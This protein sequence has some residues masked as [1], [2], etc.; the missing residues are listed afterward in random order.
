MAR[1]LVSRNAG[2]HPIAAR[3]DEPA[4]P[5]EPAPPSAR[6]HP[7]RLWGGGAL[8]VAYGVA[9]SWL[10][11]FV[12]TA[13]FLGAFPWVGGLRRPAL[14]AA[15]SV[16]GSFVLFVVFMRVAYISL[17]L[18]EGPFRTLSI[19]LLRLIGVGS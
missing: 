11:F 16:V 19:A 6:E 12:S 1:R 18:G 15:L 17:P 9:V 7:R 10:G 8:V 4:A 2:A 3:E 5:V 14:A 13:L